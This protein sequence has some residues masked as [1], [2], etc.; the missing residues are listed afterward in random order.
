MIPESFVNKHSSD[1]PGNNV[2]AVIWYANLPLN[3]ITDLIYL[4]YTSN[5]KMFYGI[6]GDSN[7]AS[8]EVIGEASWRMGKACFPDGN[9]SGANGHG[10]A[11]VTCGFHIFI[12]L[13][14]TTDFLST[15]ILHSAARTLSSPMLT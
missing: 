7:G 10:E 3:I 2:A 6:F 13:S 12:W 11:D 4:R 1:L 15:Q 14:D 5:G 8:P 9:I